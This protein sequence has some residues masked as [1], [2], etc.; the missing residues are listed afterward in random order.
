VSADL[1]F[2]TFSMA[3]WIAS[4]CLAFLGY[5]FP[6]F[7]QPSLLNTNP[8]FVG[9]QFT[10]PNQRFLLEHL[11]FSNLSARPKCVH[12][13]V[14]NSTLRAYK[15]DPPRSAEIS[16]SLPKRAFPYIYPATNPI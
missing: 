12:I 13:P 2:E 15:V 9:A 7:L 14:E 1:L 6:S 4:P 5:G 8:F 16:R 3:D 11:L 10:I